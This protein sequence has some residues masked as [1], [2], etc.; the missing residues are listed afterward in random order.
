VQLKQA[1]T[2]LDNSRRQLESELAEIVA[3][4]PPPGDTKE[5]PEDRPRAVEELHREEAALKC[6]HNVLE[7]A[8]AKAE[9]HTG[10]KVTNIT[11][12]DTGKVL[13]GLVNT[14][15]KYT[16]VDVMIDNI[17]ANKGGKVIAGVV[18]GVTID[19]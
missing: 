11:V 19:F 13:A 3:S 14:Q 12:D 2:D 10:V 15:G 4:P 9:H 5:D 1:I 8:L 16:T 6:F 7:K 17:K 18:E